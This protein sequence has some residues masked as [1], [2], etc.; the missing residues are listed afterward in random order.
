M[1]N[2]ITAIIIDPQK[3]A[4]DYSKLRT[5]FYVDA[6]DQ[7]FNVKVYKN[8]DDWLSK[9]NNYRG[10][11]CL[12]TISDGV[13]LI[14][15]TPLNEMSF[16]FRKKWID[17][18]EFNPEEISESIIRVFANN[19]NRSNKDS[20]VFSI[21]T[22]SFN[23]PREFV[24][25]L[26]NSLV[27]QTYA[28]WNWWILDDSEPNKVNFFARLNDPRIH[29]IKNV[30]DHGNIGFNKHLIASVADG[31]YLVEVDHD[32]ELTPDCLELLKKAFDTYPDTDFVYS[33]AFEEIGGCSV[34]YDTNFALGLGEY[35]EQNI[36]GF[37]FNIPTTPDV[38]A[39]SIRHIVAAPNH[40]RCWKKDFYHRIGGHNTELSVLDD[41]DILMRTFLN[42][43]MCKI[44]KVLYIQHEGEDNGDR[45]DGST[46][47]SKRY[48]EI[49][50]LGVILKN[51]YDEAI[52]NRLLE[53]G[54]EDPYWVE[55]YKYSEI[56]G[57][58]KEGT[59]PLNYTLDV[60]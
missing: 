53:L 60:D 6:K 2:K 43:K 46:T 50:R 7:S 15:Y 42:G 47:Q 40:V 37:I 45:R 22:C 57:G 13:H 10:F 4:H 54:V 5:D 27:K 16:E 18:P 3:D 8:T 48:D 31:D 14:D 11:D 44:P 35:V 58:P 33:Y 12:I 39:L 29:I 25:R 9:L 36:N 59:V 21:F 56:H 17:L 1:K 28:N 49:Q 20:Q 26:Y 55:E 32:D 51:K 19:I 41:L 30:T 38:N 23:T 24:N 52:H 34:W